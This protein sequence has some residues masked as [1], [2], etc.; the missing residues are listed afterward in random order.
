[1]SSSTITRKSGDRNSPGHGAL[2]KDVV[3]SF[4]SGDTSEEQ[5][6]DTTFDGLL[7]K[8]IV[9]VGSTGGA[10]VTVAFSIKDKDDNEILA[11]SGL[12]EGSTSQFS[13]EEPVFGGIKAGVT[14]SADPLSNLTVTIRLK[15]V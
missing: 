9:E 12:A 1:M 14:P 3:I 13:L 6:I 15:G 11:G 2:Q 4:V 8:V 10:V 5:A 7:K